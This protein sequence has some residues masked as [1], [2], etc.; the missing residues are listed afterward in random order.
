MLYD[1]TDLISSD[2]HEFSHNLHPSILEKLGLAA[3]LRRYCL[4]FSAYRKISINMTTNGEEVPI[5]PETALAL[6]RVGQECF[7]NVA[8][9]SGAVSCGVRLTYRDDCVTLDIEDQGIGFDAKR[10]KDASGLGIESMR[11]RLRFV[12]GTLRID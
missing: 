2:I 6:F 8:K 9:H 1:E 12:C 4:E 3:A 5:S 7:M 11:E 10:L